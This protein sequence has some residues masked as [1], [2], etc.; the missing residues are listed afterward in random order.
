MR[1]NRSYG[2]EGGEGLHPSRPYVRLRAHTHS[3]VEVRAG[4]SQGPVA[5]RNCVAAMRCGEQR[6]A[7]RRS[8]GDELDSAWNGDEPARRGRSLEGIGHADLAVKAM[9]G[10]SAWLE[11]E[12]RGRVCA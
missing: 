4:V 10:L 9:T 6:K 5:D 3:T 12:R 2:S 1:E 8:A 7:N 11:A